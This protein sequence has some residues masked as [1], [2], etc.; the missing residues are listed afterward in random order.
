M[1]PHEPLVDCPHSRKVQ[2]R[3]LRAWEK[4]AARRGGELRLRGKPQETKSLL[5]HLTKLNK[6]TEAVRPRRISR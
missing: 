2:E 5:E 6:E 1:R 3:P 4:R